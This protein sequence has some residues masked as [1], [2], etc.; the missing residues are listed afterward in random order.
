MHGDFVAALG[1][2]GAG[3]LDGVLRCDFC[4]E[5]EGEE[6]GEEGEK[7]EAHGCCCFLGERG[8]IEVGAMFGYW[9]E[10]SYQYQTFVQVVG[11]RGQI[12]VTGRRLGSG[13]C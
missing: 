3:V 1:F 12:L 7:R 2:A 4:G 5:G 10:R 13:P 11:D 8:R 9:K 6:E